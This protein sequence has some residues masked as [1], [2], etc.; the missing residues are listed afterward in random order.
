MRV[1]DSQRSKVYK[2]ETVIHNIGEKFETVND[3]SIY[4]RKIMN[5]DWFQ[6]RYPEKTWFDI[7]DGRGTR[8]ARGSNLSYGGVYMNLPRW[9]R[10]ESVILHELAHGLQPANTA[11]HGREFCA[12][13]IELVGRF[14]G[15]EAEKKLRE[16]FKANR[17]KYR[18]AAKASPPSQDYL[19]QPVIPQ[20][21][22]SSGLS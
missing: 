5:S 20:S 8:Y 19:A 22:S 16:S 14:M 17:V 6:Q 2:A 1:R 4:L 18:R 11:W 9:A 3:V 12:I 7:R 13:Y 10:R 15:K 21:H